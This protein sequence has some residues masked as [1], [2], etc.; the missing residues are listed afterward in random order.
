MC[1]VNYQLYG[2]HLE[3]CFMS[4]FVLLFSGKGQEYWAEENII[5]EMPACRQM[6]NI[7]HPFDPVAYRFIFAHLFLCSYNSVYVFLLLN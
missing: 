2:F 7:F 4:C 1:I 6:F 5:E 3:V